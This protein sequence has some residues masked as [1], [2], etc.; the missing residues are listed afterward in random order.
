M[1][2]RDLAESRERLRSNRN[3]SRPITVVLGAPCS[4]K[5]TYVAEH[6]RPGDVVIDFDAI[7]VAVGSPEAHDHAKQHL[8]VAHAA[9][10]AAIARVLRDNVPAWIV[11]TSRSQL[12]QFGLSGAKTH[13]MPTSIDECERRA[14]ADG[15]TQN[16]LALI[17][18]WN[19]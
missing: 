1:T 6:A 18:G 7:A 14:I 12:D 19:G 13:V 16:V 5:T 17:R 3:G 2:Y 10:E 4:G 8:L 9:R 11:L 15:R